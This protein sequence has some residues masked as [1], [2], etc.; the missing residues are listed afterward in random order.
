MTI[1]DA[2]LI[3]GLLMSVERK[4]RTNVLFGGLLIVAGFNL[5]QRTL[6]TAG[7]MLLDVAVVVFILVRLIQSIGIDRASKAEPA[8]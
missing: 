1:F 8:A 5:V 6:G 4:K 2:V 3:L 7:T